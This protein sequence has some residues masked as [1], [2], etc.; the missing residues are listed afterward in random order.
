M[1]T[2]DSRRVEKSLLAKGFVKDHG[3]HLFFRL[4]VNGKKTAI[5]TKISHGS[6]KTLGDGLVHMMAKQVKLSLPEFRDLVECRL[7]EEAYV[8]LLVESKQI[9]PGR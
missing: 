6:R 8:K 5:Y 2:L 9:E 4:F 7:S 3:D 1:A